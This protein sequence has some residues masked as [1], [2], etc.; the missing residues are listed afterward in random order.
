MK[1]NIG[2]I[3]KRI[4]LLIGVIVIVIGAQ[5]GS[6]WGVLGM[7]PII[8]SEVGISP[9]YVLFHINTISKTKSR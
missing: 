2:K 6:I 3:D 5:A 4:R 7:L 8:I 1:K 9:I